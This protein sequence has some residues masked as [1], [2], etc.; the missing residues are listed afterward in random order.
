MKGLVLAAGQGSRLRPLT[1]NLPKTLLNVAEGMTIL[2]AALANLQAN[3]ISDVAIITGFAS[4]KIE[5]IQG[6]LEARFDMSLE[7]IF[8]D[9]GE[10][11]NNA[12]SLW[13]GADWM[14]DDTII[15][16]SDTLH[17]PSVEKTL[18]DHTA[19]EESGL[20]VASDT[21]KHLG[22][23]EMKM[24]LTPEM[25]VR[26]IHK[27][28]NPAIAQGEYIGVTYVK[29]ASVDGVMRSLEA[30]WD[31]DKDMYYE[32]GF[33]DYVDRG[34]RMIAVPIG[35]VPWIEVDSHDDLAKAK[36][37]ACLY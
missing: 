36:E 29:A 12:Y 7:L 14:D 33:Q 31:R 1:D 10:I 24:T 25:Q 19:G 6:D 32:D 11:W 16:N 9:K 30:T 22:E 13:L 35:D 37:I 20:F 2:D 5:S 34:E 28:I 21:V 18:I 3:G 8:N 17:P 4:D 27:G 26:R 23:E 15:V